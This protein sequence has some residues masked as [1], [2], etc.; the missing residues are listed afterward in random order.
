MGGQETQESLW[1]T[2]RWWDVNSSSTGTRIPSLL[3][4]L[5]KTS[6]L[7]ETT[8]NRVHILF[9]LP[10]CFLLDICRFNS[11][12]S[13]VA[14]LV[15]QMVKNLPAMRETWVRKIPW[16]RTWQPTPVFLPGESPWTEEPG[17]L[18]S[19]TWLSNWAHSTQFLCY[20]FFGAFYCCITCSVTQSCLTLCD[21]MDYST[22][23]FPVFNYLPEFAQIHVHWV[24]GAI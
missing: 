10:L 2:Q 21:P 23:G 6:F 15:A 5:L 20:V 8:M 12:A 3:S 11:S 16:R 14:S 18:H 22:P 9:S 1:A 19:W 7:V 24:G 4:A 17:G 13:L